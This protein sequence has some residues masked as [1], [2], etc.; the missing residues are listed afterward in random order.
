M[1]QDGWGA[2][3]IEAPGRTER[4]NAGSGTAA[5]RCSNT[6]SSLANAISSG[7]QACTSATTMRTVATGASTKTPRTRERLRLDRHPPRKLS[8]SARWWTALSLRMARGCLATFSDRILRT[9]VFSAPPVLRTPRAAPTRP[10]SLDVESRSSPLP[11]PVRFQPDEMTRHKVR[12]GNASN[13]YLVRNS[14]TARS[15]FVYALVRQST[16]LAPG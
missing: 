12:H 1:A 15:H 16:G 10:Q 4:Q 13:S 9:P 2:P 8:R 5:E 3:R 6:S 11:V 7:S 14:I